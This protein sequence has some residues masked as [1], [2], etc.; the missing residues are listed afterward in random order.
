MREVEARLAKIGAT[1]DRMDGESDYAYR[2]SFRY[3]GELLFGEAASAAEIERLAQAHYAHLWRLAVERLTWRS[4]SKAHLEVQ[5]AD[6]LSLALQ[7]GKGVLLLSAHFGSG[8][9]ATLAALSRF[10]PLHGRA[11]FLRRP[12]RPRWLS[13]LVNRRL[14]RAGFS[15]LPER[16]SLE[17]ILAALAAGDAVVFPFDQHAGPPHGIEV[18]L[19]GHAAW[20][21]KSL[22]LLALV[23]EAAVV[24]IASW[25]DVDGRRVLR[26]EEPLAPVVAADPGLQIRLTT[27][28]YNAALERLILGHP[29]QWQWMRRRWKTFRPLARRTSSA[30]ALSTPN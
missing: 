9:A 17:A 22:A 14:R 12:I 26:F 28:A 29:E 21:L 4:T 8:D 3:D 11:H 5:N 6:V 25:R 1:I 16:A 20:T 13:H 30:R 2:A 23:S 27:R 19:F 18:D 15:A 10:P 24:P 7:R